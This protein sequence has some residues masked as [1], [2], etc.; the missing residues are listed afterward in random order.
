MSESKPRIPMISNRT[1]AAAGVLPILNKPARFAVG[2]PNGLTSNSWIVKSHSV[3]GIYIA[4]RDNF[5]EAKVSLHP[6]GKGD[7]RMAFVSKEIAQKMTGDTKREWSVWA[8]P[9]ELL[10]NLVVAIH[11]Y[12]P[13]SEIVVPPE[14]RKA[15]KWKNVI[16]IE[17]GPPGKMTIV[18]L[19]I[20]TGNL[21]P[22]HES[23]P[24][25][26]LA[27]FE[28][29]YNRYAKLVAHA[30]NEGNIQELISH[31]VSTAHELAKSKGLQ[32]PKGSFAYFF[33]ERQTG[34]RFIFGAR[35]HR[36]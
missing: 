20:T 35:M 29:G 12:F 17:A 2:D 30:E 5:N 34:A 21:N 6:K 32:P 33:G 7:W 19:F 28:I 16:F 4:C 24:S 11:L 31:G 13:T 15:S 8:E 9:P 1:L 25:F 14:L 3:S 26:V 36:D 10:P 18:T 27:S 23:E 22:I